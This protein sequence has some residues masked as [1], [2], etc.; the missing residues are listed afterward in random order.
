MKNSPIAKF[1]APKPAPKPPK[2]L[3]KAG[4][5]LWNS[6][7]SE[8][9]IH[10]AG[11]LALLLTVCRSED[12]IQRFRTALA[13]DGHTAIY[14]SFPAPRCSTPPTASGVRMMMSATVLHTNT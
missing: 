7:T 1:R 13:T 2:E 4:R 8:Y 12:D 3:G 5:A 9:E 10:D 14:Q 6:L 11:G